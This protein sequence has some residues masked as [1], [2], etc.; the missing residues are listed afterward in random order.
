MRICVL[1]L[2]LAAACASNAPSKTLK[3]ENKRLRSELKD[4][5][6]Q[7]ADTDAKLEALQAELAKR[8]ETAKAKDTEIEKLK[9][10]N[11]A[12]WRELAEARGQA[13]ADKRVPTVQCPQGTVLDATGASCVPIAPPPPPP[14]PIAPTAVPEP[15]TARILKLTIEGDFVVCVL[16]AGKEHG[17]TKA[18]RAQFLR[19]ET[20]TPL[21]GGKAEIVRVDRRTTTIRVK[22]TMDAVAAN[23]SVLLSP[24]PAAGSDQK[25]P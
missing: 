18:W 9:S 15:V 11:A 17:V 4:A 7:Q 5:R 24:A 23:P 22:M 6:S 25:T 8:D 13:A 21:V 20:T 12:T 10:E 16:G 3:A 19:A 1:L 2:L 14:P